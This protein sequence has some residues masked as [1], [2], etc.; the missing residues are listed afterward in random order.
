MTETTAVMTT[1]LDLLAERVERA[2]NLVQQLRTDNQRLL[3]EREEMTARLRDVEA[4]LEGAEKKMQGQDVTALL[5][6]L[7]DLR[8]LQRDWQGERRDVATK[9]EGLL[10]K[11]DRL[12]G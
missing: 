9:I 8:R 5:G 11:L 3:G 4:R 10:K 1:D 2:A 7:T 6:E 12:E